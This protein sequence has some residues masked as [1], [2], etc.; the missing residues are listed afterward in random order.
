MLKDIID[1]PWFHVSN[2]GTKN[3]CCPGLIISNAPFSKESASLQI[4]LTQT[5]DA[6]LAAVRKSPKII[7]LKWNSI[8]LPQKNPGKHS[9][10]GVFAQWCQP[11]GF[12]FYFW[13]HHAWLEASQ[14]VQLVKNLPV[15]PEI[16]E[17]WVL[18]LGWEELL[19]KKTATLPS[20]IFWDIP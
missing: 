10:A 6:S 18:F 5:L 4:V 19:E 12:F 7:V 17:M 15:M 13:Q 11:P 2:T 9:R 8:S 14:V 20:I 3:P 1:L 16:Q